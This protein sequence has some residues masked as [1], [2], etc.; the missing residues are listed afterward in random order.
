MNRIYSVLFAALCIVP[1]LQADKKLN[2]NIERLAYYIAIKSGTDSSEKGKI[3]DVQPISEVVGQ[4]GR[5]N[6]I[7]LGL[8]AEVEEGRDKAK[9]FLYAWQ[10]SYKNNEKGLGLGGQWIFRPYDTD[11]GIILGGKAGIGKQNMIG[12]TAVFSTNADKALYVTSEP[13]DNVPTQV[14]YVEDTYVISL[15]FLTG[16]SYTLTKDI[17]LELNLE[18]RQDT[19]QSAYINVNAEQIIHN[20]LTFKQDVWNTG[21]YMSYS[22]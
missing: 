19:Y 9:V 5:R 2:L 16:L 20:G 14:E 8:S 18:Y 22:F 1:T 3:L 12:K 15:A 10:N 6:E 21:F 4:N 13:Q 11:L 17:E 7:H